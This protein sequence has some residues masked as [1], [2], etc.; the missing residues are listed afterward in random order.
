MTVLNNIYS[1]FLLLLGWDF[2]QEMEIVYVS[3]LQVEL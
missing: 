1:G 3:N 2:S